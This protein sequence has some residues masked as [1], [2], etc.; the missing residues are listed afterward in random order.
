MQATVVFS[1]PNLYTIFADEAKNNYPEIT[2]F[3]N[4][5]DLLDDYSL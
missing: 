5:Y 3:I 1:Y 2:N 4:I